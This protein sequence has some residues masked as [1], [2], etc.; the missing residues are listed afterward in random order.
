MAVIRGNNFLPR[1][2]N[3]SASTSFLPLAREQHAIIRWLD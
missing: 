1:T 3:Q 2:L